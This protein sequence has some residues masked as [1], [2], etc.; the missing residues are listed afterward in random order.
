MASSAPA[1]SMPSQYDILDQYG[2][3]GQMDWDEAKAIQDALKENERQEAKIQRVR[4]AFL[5]RQQADDVTED[6]DDWV[7]IEASS[8]TAF[9]FVATVV[10]TPAKTFKF[11][12]GTS[13]INAQQIQEHGFLPS[14]G[15]LLG[16]GVCAL[17]GSNSCT[18]LDALACV[19]QSIDSPGC[20]LLNAL[21][22]GYRH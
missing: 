21:N 9:A 4:E 18:L 19:I 10:E 7:N 16:R 3:T 11:Y 14:D 17:C 2:L 5:G 6:Q 22:A 15:G 1:A 12:H 13:W 8:A 20:T